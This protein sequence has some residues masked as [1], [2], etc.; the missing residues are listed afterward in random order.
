MCI[1]ITMFIVFYTLLTSSRFFQHV[2]KTPILSKSVRWG[3]N[4]RS[5]ISVVGA[6][7]MILG[8]T[9]YAIK[10]AVWVL[11]AP[12]LY[13]GA[14]SIGIVK[15]LGGFGPL[16]NFRISVLGDDATI[17]SKDIW[18]GDLNSF[19]PTLATVLIEGL[20]ISVSLFGICFVLAFIL[21]K[22]GKN[23]AEH[24]RPDRPL[25]AP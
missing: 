18:I 9:F 13:T 7:G 24:V 21:K 6:L 14:L 19:Y 12:D 23:K 15:S 8:K 11:F 10:E 5:S 4:L 25:T 20:I 2:I 17:R 22:I 16:K 1:G 3:T